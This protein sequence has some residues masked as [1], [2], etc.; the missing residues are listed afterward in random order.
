MASLIWRILK[1]YVVAIL[2]VSS[3]Y[4]I[5]PYL[6]QRYS[7]YQRRVFVQAV[8]QK[9]EERHGEAARAGKSAPQ[10]PANW[11]EQ[12]WILFCHVG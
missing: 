8:L 4:T 11:I 12:S 3:V 5:A 2:I 1:P 6:I 7:A 10:Q 9:L